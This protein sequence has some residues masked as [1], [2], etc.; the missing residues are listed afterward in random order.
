MRTHISYTE[1]LTG[2]CGKELLIKTLT[3]TGLRRQAK[4]QYDHQFEETRHARCGFAV[5][6]ASLR[7]SKQEHTTTVQKWR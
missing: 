7:T 3:C 2:R 4:L 6:D 1:L 5:P